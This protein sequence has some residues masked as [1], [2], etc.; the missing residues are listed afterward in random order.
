MIEISKLEFKELE[1]KKVFYN[2]R[3]RNGYKAFTKTVHKFYI[4]ENREILSALR[5]LRKR[6]KAD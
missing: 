3:K 5:D 2:F 1:I 4:V 6:K